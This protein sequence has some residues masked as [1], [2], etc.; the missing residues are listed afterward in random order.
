MQNDPSAPSAPPSRGFASLITLVSDVS[1]DLAALEQ[2]PVEPPRPPPQPVF[3][4]RKPDVTPVPKPINSKPVH[5]KPE[6]ARTGLP[7]WAIGFIIIIIIQG[8]L[9]LIS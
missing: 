1:K 8:L 9:R 4:E 7:A 3:T 6:P 5:S 2:A